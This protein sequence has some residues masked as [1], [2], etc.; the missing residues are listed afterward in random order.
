MIESAVPFQ[1][2]DTPLPHVV[3]AQPRWY[4][5]YVITRH[6]KAV[7]DQ[8]LRRSVEAFVP[9]YRAVHYWNKRR[10]E[11]ELPFFPSYAFVHIAPCERLRVLEVPGVVRIVSF[12]GIFASLPDEEIEALRAALSLRRSQPYPYFVSGERVRIRAGALKGLE[13]IV[14][15]EKN[16]SRLIVSVDFIQRSVRIELEPCDLECVAVEA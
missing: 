6:E 14:V 10:A 11:V 9:L 2:E 15:K 5:A 4:V 12:N 3:V 7:A 16:A 1:P 8:L 13:G